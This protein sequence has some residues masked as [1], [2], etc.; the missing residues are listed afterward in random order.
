MVAGWVKF[1]QRQ[2]TGSIAWLNKKARVSCVHAG[3][4]EILRPNLCRFALAPCTDADR[5]CRHYSE[6]SDR[7]WLG[8][9]REDASA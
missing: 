4:P 9:T 3:F 6:K 5:T 2:L 1:C 8:N 7:G